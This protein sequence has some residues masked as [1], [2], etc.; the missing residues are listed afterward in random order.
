MAKTQAALKPKTKTDI[1]AALADKTGLN[2]KEIAGVFDALT[3]LLGEELGTKGPGIVNI[4]GLMKVKVVRKPATQARPGINPF[5][6]EEI[7]I[8]AKP[9]HNV[10][11]VTPL[12]GLK[13][14]V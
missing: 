9:A 11:K 8:K 3:E 13:D 2:K 10:V 14:M 7:M 1:M 12:K 4:P 5:T 6:K